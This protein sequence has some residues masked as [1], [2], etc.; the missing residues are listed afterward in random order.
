M[1]A[2]DPAD[3]KKANA[4][5][6]QLKVKQ[7]S[8]GKLELPNWDQK[9][10]DRVRAAILVL[11]STMTDTSKAFGTKEETD[12]AAHLIGSAWGWGANPVKAARYFNVVPKMN[13]GKTPYVLTVKDV[14]K[15]RPKLPQGSLPEPVCL[16]FTVSL[17]ELPSSVRLPV[18]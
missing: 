9:S 6:D 11:A 18:T 14:S 13:D 10:Q 4:L 16:A 17:R 2:A 5:Q 1:N 7:A 15:P 8:K 12:S 3:I